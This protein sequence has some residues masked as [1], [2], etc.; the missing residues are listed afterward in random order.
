MILNT[1]QDTRQTPTTTTTEN[2]LAQIINSAEAEKPDGSSQNATDS[3]YHLFSNVSLF[4]RHRNEYL[5]QFKNSLSKEFFPIYDCSN[6]IPVSVCSR[7]IRKM[8]FFCNFLVY[9]SLESKTR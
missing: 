5:K 9:S 2:D 1:T 3:F 7:F 4:L 6:N 8:G